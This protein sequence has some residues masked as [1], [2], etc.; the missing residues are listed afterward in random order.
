[1]RLR[2]PAARRPRTEPAA[3]REQRPAPERALEAAPAVRR[4]RLEPAAVRVARLA[5]AVPAARWLQSEP[6]AEVAPGVR[7]PLS[8]HHLGP[9]EVAAPSDL[10]SV[11]CWRLLAPVL[12]ERLPQAVARPR[13]ALREPGLLQPVFAGRP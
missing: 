11:R 2:G 7:S 13:A 4:P 8:R 6:V 12:R 10:R 1:M 5:E 9:V 3:E